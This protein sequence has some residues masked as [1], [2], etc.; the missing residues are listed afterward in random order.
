MKEFFEKMKMIK[1]EVEEILGNRKSTED[2]KYSDFWDEQEWGKE[3]E[4]RRK[5][6]E[7]LKEADRIEEELSQYVIENG[8]DKPE[9]EFYIK[10]I[11]SSPDFFDTAAYSK[12]LDITEEEYK[13]YQEF[14]ETVNFVKELLAV[15]RFIE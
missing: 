11:S 13:K 3:T 4:F 10:A 14:R 5:L 1:E 6:R 8:K 9:T 7:F 12:Y 2:F 15:F